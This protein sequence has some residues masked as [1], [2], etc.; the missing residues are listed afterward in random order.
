MRNTTRSRSRRCNGGSRANPV[1][2][3]RSIRPAKWRSAD[4]GDAPRRH[5]PAEQEQPHE[6]PHARR[7]GYERGP[8][9]AT[10]PGPGADRQGNR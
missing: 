3:S 10:D 4:H 1:G 2:D 7:V 8:E 6:V 5:R 9:D